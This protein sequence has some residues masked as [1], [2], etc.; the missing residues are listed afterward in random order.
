MHGIDVSPLIPEAKPITEKAAAVY[1]KHTAPWFIGLLVHGSALKGGIVPGCSDVDLQLYLQTAAF[2]PQKHLPLELAFAIH[3]D[4][5]RIDPAPFRYIQ[6]YPLSS[7][8]PEGF[9]GPVPGA[10]HVVAGE[11]PVPEA[12]ADQLRAAS[13]KALAE[14]DPSPEF[15][16]GCLIGPGGVRLA[17]RI[18]LL[19]TK[20]WP[21]LYQVL[22]LQAEDAIEVWGLPKPEAVERLP[23][24]TPL[25]WAIRGFYRAV[26]AYYPTEDSVEGAFTVI[27]NGFAFLEA[28]KA[29]WDETSE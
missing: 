11:L 19:C 6:C 26:R 17:R 10:Y 24:S 1:L 15:I 14:L 29:W 2:T 9:V 21:V 8:L 28:A 22:T 23:G 27:E 4:I 5:A 18:R 16:I 13:K 25:G 12:T 7:E 3:R 20:V